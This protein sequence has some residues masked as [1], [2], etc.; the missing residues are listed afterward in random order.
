MSLNTTVT[1]MQQAR[2]EEIPSF[3]QIQKKQFVSQNVDDINF[4]DEDDNNSI[5]PNN[6]PPNNAFFMDALNGN[7]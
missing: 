5:K 4:E 1:T 7:H 3:E 6:A 2:P